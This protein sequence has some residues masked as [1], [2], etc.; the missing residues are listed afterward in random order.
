[1]STGA[2]VGYKNEND[3]FRGTSVNFDGD[4]VGDELNDK[5][6]G[7]REALVAWVER[8]IRETGYRDT[9]ET[10]DEGDEELYN[11]DQAVNQGDYLWMI[12]E[13]GEVLA[14]EV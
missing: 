3:V 12:S 5:F 6:K 9:D 11:F 4:L 7:D 10:Y 2:I 8:G 14:V 13:Q 1:M